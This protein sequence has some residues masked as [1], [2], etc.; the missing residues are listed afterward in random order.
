MTVPLFS[1]S[2]FEFLV[3]FFVCGVDIGKVDFFGHFLGVYS[4]CM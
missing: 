3:V 4:C 1:C 2:L